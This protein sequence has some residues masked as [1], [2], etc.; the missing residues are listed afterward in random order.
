MRYRVGEEVLAKTG[1]YEGMLVATVIIGL[2]M[3]IGFVIG[4]WR[5]RQ[6]WLAIWGGGLVIA[7]LVYLTW[8]A[9]FAP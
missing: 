2:L 9:F 1:V 4:G 8:A 6:Y 7:S 3:G 5:G